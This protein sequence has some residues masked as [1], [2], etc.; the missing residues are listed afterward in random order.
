MPRSAVAIP[1]GAVEELSSEVSPYLKW[2]G[3]KRSLLHEI[4]PRIPS[5]IHTYVEPFVGAGAVFFALAS[6]QPRRFER[7]LLS[8]VNPDLIATYHALQ[9]D[10]E[11]LLAHLHEHARRHDPTHYYVT[12][13]V[14]PT[15]LSTWER[16]AR[17][18]YLNKTCFNG[19]WRVNKSGKFNVPKGDHKNPKICNEPVLRAAA[20]AL[21]HA[22]VTLNSFEPAI[23]AAGKG[24]FC[25][26]DPPYMPS[27]KTSSFVSFAEG[28]FGPA[29]QEKLAD[30][31]LAATG[32]GCSVLASNAD[33]EVAVELY[34]SRGFKIERVDAPGRIAASKEKRGERKEILASKGGWGSS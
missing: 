9:T 12:R 14:D 15:T 18:I 26:L 29:T 2:A 22:V 31:A 6:E 3:S 19:L 4:L 28:G 23:Q 16:A 32:R 21:K 13:D 33:V 20:E 11:G 10:V 17:M 25:Y 1:G 8:D 27:S 5:K 30:V 34:E 24:D 7:A